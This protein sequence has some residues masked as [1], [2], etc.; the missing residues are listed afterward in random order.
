MLRRTKA[1]MMGLMLSVAALAAPVHAQAPTIDQELLYDNPY[2]LLA[3]AGYPQ[4]LTAAAMQ[5]AALSGDHIAELMLGF[6]YLEGVGVKKDVALG[7]ALL[8]KAE[9]GGM[10]RAVGLLCLHTPNNPMRERDCDTAVARNLPEGQLIEVYKL[11]GALDGKP[12]DVGRY[13]SLLDAAVRQQITGARMLYAVHLET[14]DIYPKDEAEAYRQTWLAA[15]D[16]DHGAMVDMASRMI[17]GKGRAADPAA[18]IAMLKQAADLGDS[19]ARANLGNRYLI[20]D[21]VAVDMELALAYLEGAATQG[22]AAAVE[23]L[24]RLYTT[25]G[26]TF[27]PVSAEKWLNT[28]LGDDGMADVGVMLALG[29]AYKNGEQVAKDPAKAVRYLRECEDVIAECALTL[30]MMYQLGTDLPRD[31]AEALRLYDVAAGLGSDE[32]AAL[33]AAMQ[34]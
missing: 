3:K 26:P 5:R 1:V 31:T 14:G 16:G 33:L 7:T 20:G 29:K 18:G 13:R 19:H 4:T 12:G 2:K 32:A 9:A 8:R 17:N 6:A 27:S 25:E 34:P 21:M 28:M 15:L 24:T 10:T 23:A 30:G 11:M 22:D